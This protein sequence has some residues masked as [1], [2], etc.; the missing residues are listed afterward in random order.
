M[1]KGVS[2]FSSAGIDE[3][4]LKDIGFN[5]VVANEKIKERADLYQKMY[6]KC[7]MICGDITDTNIFGEL[8]NEISKHKID[9]LIATPPC[10]GVSL[11]GKNKSM[12]QM[13]TDHR[14]QLIMKAIEIIKLTKPKVILIENV[15]R[16]KDLYLTYK[17]K[18]H[19]VENIL[20]KELVDYT[21]RVEVI[22]ATD[23]GVP[24]KRAR[25]IFRLYK[26]DINWE[27]PKKEDEITLRQAIGHLPT[28]EA[29]EDS[30]IKWHYARK[31]T[32]EH[33]EWMKNTNEGKSAFENKINYP[34][35]KDGTRIKG[36][37]ATY[38]R[39]K[40]DKPAPTITMRNDAIS[41][42]TNVHPGRIKDDGTVSDARVLTPREL[43][44]LTS[45]PPEPVI[46]L[47]TKESLIRKVIGE[48]F[49]PLVL[50]KIFSKINIKND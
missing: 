33:V 21:L 36:Y 20:K 41:S 32:K 23:F 31:H 2:L 22:S 1:Y 18:L 40:W 35:K 44:I 43:Y 46:P 42:Q 28:L 30:G 4:Y 25:V 10:Q 12:E 17:N 8:K 13:T 49:P 29:G 16:Y 6:G 48:S 39:M 26:K 45:L 5:V 19:T 38:A 34:R 7:K 15:P 9:F 24:Q 50:K 11:A 14:N 27:L 47:K 3:Y 37:K